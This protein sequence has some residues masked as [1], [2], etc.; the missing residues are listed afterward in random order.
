LRAAIIKG[1]LRGRLHCQPAS[2]AC[3]FHAVVVIE[4]EY[5]AA[6]VKNTALGF[7]AGA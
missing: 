2:L 3:A 5:I 1:W 6:L 7:V 4:A